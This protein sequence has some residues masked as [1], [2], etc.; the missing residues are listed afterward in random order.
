MLTLLPNV[1]KNAVYTAL[2]VM[3]GKRV[4]GHLFFMALNNFIYVKLTK[5]DMVLEFTQFLPLFT[6]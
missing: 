1:E 4:E 5:V 2:G 3:R 6:T